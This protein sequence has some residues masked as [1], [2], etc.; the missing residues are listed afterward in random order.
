MLNKVLNYFKKKEEE[1][2]VEV[3]PN[4]K[5]AIVIRSFLAN[6]YSDI[7]SSV[8]CHYALDPDGELNASVKISDCNKTVVIHNNYYE[9]KE[10]FL[11][12]I[13]VLRNCLSEYIN[14]V[15]NIK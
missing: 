6:E 10:S 7:S 2:K 13:K 5:D 9:T 4:P 3:V 11:K 8:Y 14:K 12:R 1:K 15:E